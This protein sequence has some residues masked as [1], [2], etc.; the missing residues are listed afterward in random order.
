MSPSPRKSRAAL[1][2]PHPAALAAATAVVVLGGCASEAVE[3]PRGPQFPAPELQ[4]FVPV[5]D[6]LIAGMPEPDEK[7]NRELDEYKEI[8]LGITAADARLKARAE[9]AL[10]E[11]PFAWCALEPALAHEDV[12]VRRR[13]AWLAGQSGQSELQLP[14][15]HRL[16]YEKDAEAV[17]WVADALQRLGNDTGAQWLDAAMTSEA[18]ANVAG[19]RAIAI[20]QQRGI[21]LDD[22]PT[23]DQ[24]RGAMQAITK[25]WRQT[26]V[27]A[28]PDFEAPAGP[29]L[30]ARIAR[31][32]ATTQFTQ[33]RPID[34]AR[35]VLTRAGKVGL[36]LLARALT[37]S[38]HYLR[39]TALQILAELGTCANEVGPDVM[40]L[41]GDP[42]TAPLAVRTLGEIGE[43]AAIPHLRP[44][45][46]AIDSESR[47]EAAKALG[48]LGDEPSRK[49]LQ[50]RLDD[51]NETLDVRVSAAFGL[52]CLGEHAQA[53]AFL[54]E[55]E[56]K[57]D[58]HAPM[59]RRLR[60]GLARRQH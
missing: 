17:V 13:A 40:K 19:Q 5:I 37:A 25:T 53:E 51:P 49:A 28:A 23:Y 60:E 39:T 45:L 4:P 6:E 56:Q 34:D 1:T 11:H 31:R 14:L 43:I 18:T 12:G 46:D 26:G 2:A 35:Y 54:S 57:G 47:S 16:K 36:P 22:N 8:A 52:L 41:L 48:L 29:Q 32:L 7:A 55:R 33:L 30:D 50:A 42:F 20:C 21:E 27:G 9:R 44:M 10:L 58:Y 3:K 15:L 59:L 38:E 24:L